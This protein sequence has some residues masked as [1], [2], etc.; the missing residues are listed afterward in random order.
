MRRA[1]RRAAILPESA[2]RLIRLAK[3]GPVFAHDLPR[4]LIAVLR[5]LARNRFTGKNFFVVMHTRV[6]HFAAPAIYW[7]PFI[8]TNFDAPPLVIDW[9]N[10]FGCGAPHDMNDHLR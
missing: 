7:R 8:R 2:M 5:V 10:S 3:S 6:S 4:W 9:N 1:I